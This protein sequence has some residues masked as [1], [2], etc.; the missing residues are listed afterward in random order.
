MS[1]VSNSFASG[2]RYLG[3]LLP[4]LI[5]RQLV[6]LISTCALEC[7][8][9]LCGRLNLLCYSFRGLGEGLGS[10]SENLAADSNDVINKKTEIGVSQEKTADSAEAVIC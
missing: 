4:Q 6:A 9:F 2:A 1:R 3:N 10:I 7:R 8:F 5:F